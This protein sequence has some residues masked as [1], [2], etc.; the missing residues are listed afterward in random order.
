LYR[1]RTKP[2]L[3]D[4]RRALRCLGVE[5]TVDTL[6]LKVDL[7]AAAGT[8]IG[9]IAAAGGQ[10]AVAGAAVAVTVV[11]YLAGRFKARRKSITSSP[12]AHLLAADRKL[13]NWWSDPTSRKLS[14]F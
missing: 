2:Q 11:P 1:S 10:L 6:G 12:V 5:S 4:L 3:D 13:P 14:R 9:S 7:N 8:V